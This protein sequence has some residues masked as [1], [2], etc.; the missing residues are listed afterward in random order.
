[1]HG[2]NDKWQLEI[3]RA[4]LWNTDIQSCNASMS[5]LGVIHVMLKDTV[6]SLSLAKDK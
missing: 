2:R 6:N 5:Y 3:I 1:M 4:L